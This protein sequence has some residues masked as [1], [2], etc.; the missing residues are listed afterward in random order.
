MQKRRLLKK[1]KK[2]DS[3]SFL[4]GLSPFYYLAGIVNWTVLEAAK[5]VPWAEKALTCHE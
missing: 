1:I 2:G 4:K 3:P 5:S